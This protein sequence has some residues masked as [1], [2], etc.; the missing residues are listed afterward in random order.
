MG[1][2]EMMLAYGANMHQAD[3]LQRAPRSAF[4]GIARLE[5]WRIGVSRSG[6]LGVEPNTDACVWGALYQLG[7]G[8]E[9]R[10]DEYEAVGR[11]LYRKCRLETIGPDGR[12]VALVY[13]PNEP[14]DG[15]VRGEYLARCIDAAAEIGLSA[16]WIEG[17]RA[18]A[19]IRR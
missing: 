5:G 4:L 19:T 10:L 13:V 14:L 15:V 11:G 1:A 12:V 7:E 3:M 16:E 18:L 2:A 8:D 17:L 9:P 6:W